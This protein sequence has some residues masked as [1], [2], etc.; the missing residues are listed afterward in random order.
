M[1]DVD[2]EIGWSLEEVKELLGHSGH[3][4]IKVTERYA[5]FAEGALETAAKGTP[6]GGGGG[7]SGQR[8]VSADPENTARPGRF[9]LPTTGSV[10]PRGLND[11][12]TLG[13]FADHALTNLAIAVVEAF[14]TDDPRASELAVELATRVIDAAPGSVTTTKTAKAG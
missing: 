13:A 6:G 12:A 1:K 3:S 5:H 10:D 9:E 4:T 7:G 2:V 14:A 11:S 8:V